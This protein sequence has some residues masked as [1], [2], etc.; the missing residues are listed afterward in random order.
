[1]SVQA[2]IKAHY[3][4][5]HQT[6]RFLVAAAPHSG[7]WLLALR[8]A[9]AFRLGCSVCFAVAVSPVDTHG[10]CVLVCKK[11]PRETTKN[12]V[13]YDAI[14]RSLITAGVPV[15]IAMCLT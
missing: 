12:H 10:L 13:V 4:D 5:Q 14:T 9:V 15:T 7:D 1:M 2:Q 3:S 8:V 11:S 6:A